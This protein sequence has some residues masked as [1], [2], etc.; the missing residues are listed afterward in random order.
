MEKNQLK[1]H[2][3][4]LPEF[5]GL[6][7]IVA[8][9]GAVVG[10]IFGIAQIIFSVQFFESGQSLFGVVVLATAFLTIIFSL[11]GL[12]VTQCFLV[13]VKSQVDIRNAIVLKYQAGLSK[14]EI[15][16]DFLVATT[17]NDNIKQSDSADGIQW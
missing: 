8:T 13:V 16:I 4:K 14:S 11:V 5:Y 17:P 3:D 6:I 9:V 1:K 2:I 7:S 15:S 10:C 12:G